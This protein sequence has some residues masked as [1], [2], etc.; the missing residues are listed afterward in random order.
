[1]MN[2][3]S[4][5]IRN[6]RIVDNKKRRLR[7]VRRQRLLLAVFI[8]ALISITIFIVS[9]MILEAHSEATEVKYYTAVD[10]HAG[11]TL[12]ELSNNYISYT[13]YNDINSYMNEVKRI[14]HLDE[15]GHIYA[16][17]KIIFPYY[18]IYKE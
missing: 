16:G 11:D 1:M 10:I 14:N 13:H 3:T 15:V 6:I 8:A 2:T 4:M 5:T 17:T 18:S 12:Y 9:T 7:I